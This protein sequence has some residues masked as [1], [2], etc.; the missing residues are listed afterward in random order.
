LLAELLAGEQL[1]K[2][3]DFAE[4]SGLP[5][6]IGIVAVAVL[7][8]LVN[9]YGEE[10]G[11]RGFALPLLQRRFTPLPA[12]LL[13]A[14]IWA[15]WHLPMFLVVNSF[16]G[17]SAGTVVGWLLGLTAGSIVLGW[18]YNSSGG[19]V[20][21]VAVWH[22]GFN[23]VTAT[24]AGTGLIAAIVTTVVMVQAIVLVG[25]EL[26]ARRRGRP[27][28]LGQQGQHPTTPIGN[29]KQAITSSLPRNAPQQRPPNGDRGQRENRET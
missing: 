20:A 5:S 22:A 9:G 16:R 14:A 19:S 24:A 23:M 2:M 4:M 13:L 17:F 28:V 10:T 26:F 3:A 7:V 8:L 25:A 29:P 18:L 11:W 21:L 15:G 27:S 6:T 12:M 1:P